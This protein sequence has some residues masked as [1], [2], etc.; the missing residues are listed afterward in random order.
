MRRFVRGVVRAR[1]MRHL[2]LAFADRVGGIEQARSTPVDDLLARIHCPS[3]L[4]VADRLVGRLVCFANGGGIRIDGTVTGKVLFAGYVAAAHP[5]HMFSLATAPG[6]REAAEKSS[7]DLCEWLDGAMHAARGADSRTLIR[8]LETVGPVLM[9]YL[10]DFKKWR[11]DHERAMITRTEEMADK[12]D[13]LLRVI[14]LRSHRAAGLRRDA[15]T[16]RERLERM[17]TNS[18]SST[19]TGL[20]LRQ[21]AHEQLSHDM[22]VR[23]VQPLEEYAVTGVSATLAFWD[24]VSDELARVPPVKKN[25]Q[26]VIHEVCVNLRQLTAGMS[27]VGLSCIEG[28]LEADQRGQ[29]DGLRR[30][31]QLVQ[32]VHALTSSE[33][34]ES[35][36]CDLSEFAYVMWTPELLVLSLRV[37]WERVNALCLLEIQRRHT[38]LQSS[39]QGG[40]VEWERKRFEATVPRRGDPL[41]TT[42]LWLRNTMAIL[43]TDPSLRGRSGL[44]L[45]GDEGRELCVRESW[46]RI[47]S[48]GR[49]KWKELPEV[50]RLDRK[51]LAVMQGVFVLDALGKVFVDAL[52]LVSLP[53]QGACV[54]GLRLHALLTPPSP[55]R[56]T[57]PSPRRTSW[58]GAC[59]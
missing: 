7:L 53:C 31:M 38:V 51:R 2:L 5:S 20:S 28:L 57:S 59:V 6:L 39:L 23:D 37:L 42:R 11:I 26:K 41:R 13:G 25:A 21:G 9:C 44:P 19:P 45:Q 48:E 33:P 58:R 54:A 49:E 36:A 55:H 50:C 12:I 22:M 52:R 1:S 32:R 8:V 35:P 43:C 3:F 18:S 47:V 10:R 16:I 17:R 29:V 30:A 27:E 56:R 15:Q 34:F 40:G 46:V 14:P 24:Q 4:H